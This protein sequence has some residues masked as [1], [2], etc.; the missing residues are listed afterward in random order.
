M[1]NRFYQNH[2]IILPLKNKK[3]KI[4][5]DVT[6]TEGNVTSNNLKKSKFNFYKKIEKINIHYDNE[7]ENNFQIRS[8]TNK[9]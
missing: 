9:K 4:A 7:I 6:K 1:R 8:I 3:I 2:K 5:K